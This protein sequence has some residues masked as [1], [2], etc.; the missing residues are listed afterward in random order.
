CLQI[1]GIWDPPGYDKLDLSQAD[2]HISTK[3]TKAR[4]ATL[5]STVGVKFKAERYWTVTEYHDFEC[6]AGHKWKA[7]V[8]EVISSI[9]AGTNACKQCSN[10]K[11]R[12]DLKNLKEA[13]QSRGFILHTE[14]YKNSITKYLT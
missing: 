10:E 2:C 13:Y 1:F 5:C 6:S 3:Y 8:C 4:I 14:D 11:L 12:F 9:K 7:Q